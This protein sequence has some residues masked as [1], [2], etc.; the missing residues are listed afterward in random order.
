MIQVSKFMQ[1]LMPLVIGCPEPIAQQALV[2]SAIAFCERSLVLTQ[3]LDATNTTAGVDTYDFVLPQGHAVATVL[4]AW[5][6]TTPLHPLPTAAAPH[7]VTTQAVP[8]FFYGWDTDEGFAL[9][10]RPVPDAVGALVIRVALKPLR[11]ATQLHQ[12]LFNDWIEPVIDGAAARIKAIPDQHY[13]DL[14]LA[15][16]L[17]TKAR[18]AANAARVDGIY[19][20]AQAEA[21][22]VMRPFA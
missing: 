12:A 7:M 10:L 17:M 2:D 20:K 19:G 16:V 8:R 3:T 5:Y 1:R 18:V 14:A 13:T 22:V 9:K 11:D 21:S 4:A 6:E 15:G